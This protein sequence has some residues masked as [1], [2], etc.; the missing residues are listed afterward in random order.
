MLSA[1]I[2]RT[3]YYTDQRQ[4]EVYKNG[5][6]DIGNACVKWQAGG[7]RLPTEAEW[8]YA[9]R[10][11]TTTNYYWQNE[12]FNTWDGEDAKWR[13]Y[14]QGNVPKFV[15]TP[16]PVAQKKP[17]PFGLYAS[18]D[19]PWLD[20]DYFAQPDESAK[21]KSDEQ[22]DEQLNEQR[23][24]KPTVAQQAEKESTAYV[25]TNNH[26]DHFDSSPSFYDD[27][28]YI[29]NEPN[30]GDKPTAQKCNPAVGYVVLGAVLGFIVHYLMTA[31]NAAA[32]AC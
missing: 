29:T 22:P 9:C 20:E 6:I 31:D 24:E 4:T 17:N 30:L 5:R 3:S 23:E 19:E 8:E 15:H 1:L 26:H 14:A 27:D 18:L 25:D 16:Q 7:F 13:E 28:Y 11:G 10:G 21:Q 32:T 2:I 12:I